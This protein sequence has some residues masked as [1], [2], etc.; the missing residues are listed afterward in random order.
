MFLL[1]VSTSASAIGVGPV[2][3]RI[4]FEPNFA[5]EYEF[6]IYNND[7]INF[8]AE[9]SISGELKDYITM[10]TT[11]LVFKADEESKTVSFTVNLPR[12]IPPGEYES[13]ITIKEASESSSMIGAVAA[14]SHKLTL[15]VPKH[16]KYI[17]ITTIKDDKKIVVTIKNIGLKEVEKI[18]LTNNIF[19]EID[20]NN[21]SNIINNLLPDQ[22]YNFTISLN[23]T[24]GIYS[25]NILLNYDGLIK[26]ITETI[27]IGRINITINNLTI[28]NFKL[29]EIN[30]LDITLTTDWNQPIDNLIAEVDVFKNKELITTIKGPTT[31]IEK[32]KTLELFIDTKDYSEGEYKFVTKVLR[33]KE[34]V[35]QKEFLLTLKKSEVVTQKK[36]PLEIII[37]SIIVLVLALIIL[38]FEKRKKKKEE[39]TTKEKD[40]EKETPIEETEKNIKTE[41]KK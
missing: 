19:S 34:L 39:T 5:K 3:T 11:S 27:I 17:K 8:N 13:R 22:D 2:F 37:L 1:I 25:H 15:T 30:Q 31:T 35:S 36:L 41:K 14:V 29:G 28:K 20:S 12:D 9:L 24:S 21:Y 40:E 6:T 7:K 16:G 23:Q 18:E 26:N 33:N 4:D 32:N 38:L 10:D